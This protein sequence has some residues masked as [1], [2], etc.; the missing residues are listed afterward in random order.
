[1]GPGTWMEGFGLLFDRTPAAGAATFDGYGS[2]SRRVWPH[3]EYSKW[4][5]R[6][7]L[8]SRYTWPLI[9]AG[10]ALAACLISILVAARRSKKRPG[11]G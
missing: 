1:V 9:L 10:A 4:P 8:M 11:G 5:E 6:S 3:Y 7:W 2:M